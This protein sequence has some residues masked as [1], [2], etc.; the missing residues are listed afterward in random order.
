MTPMTREGANRLCCIKPSAAELESTLRNYVKTYKH[1]IPQRALMHKTP[2][3]A[4]KE[5]NENCPGLLRKCVYNQTGLDTY[6]S[7]TIA[8]RF[9]PLTPVLQL[10]LETAHF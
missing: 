3:Q 7:A 2:I 10:V 1:N 6:G 8:G 9:D 5:W 4:L